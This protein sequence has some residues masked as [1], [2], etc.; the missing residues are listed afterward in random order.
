MVIL[1]LFLAGTRRFAAGMRPTG[2]N[3]LPVRPVGVPVM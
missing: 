2:E 1:I 3:I